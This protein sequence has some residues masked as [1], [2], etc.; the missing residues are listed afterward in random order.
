MNNLDSIE[1]EISRYKDS[2]IL[3]H[4]TQTGEVFKSLVLEYLIFKLNG[5]TYVIS[6]NDRSDFYL[7]TDEKGEIDYYIGQSKNGLKRVIDRLSL[8]KFAS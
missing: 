4:Y 1:K 5:I 8:T 2:E 6:Y 7:M 3:K